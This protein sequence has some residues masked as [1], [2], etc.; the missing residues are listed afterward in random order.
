M[1]AIASDGRYAIIHITQVRHVPVAVGIVN[2][3]CLVI[4]TPVVKDCGVTGGIAAMVA[5]VA[6]IAVARA[7]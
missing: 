1:F 4:V 3:A 2:T 5:A 6:T 7:L